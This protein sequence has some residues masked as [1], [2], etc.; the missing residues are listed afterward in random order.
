[1]EHFNPTNREKTVIVLK[2]TMQ[3]MGVVFMSP[4]EIR[5][6]GKS[7]TLFP[8]E[9]PLYIHTVQDASKGR[10]AR[11]IVSPDKSKIGAN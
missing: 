11:A 2:A 9:P 5:I 10:P 6:G 7:Q 1:M 4:D 8:S 3:P